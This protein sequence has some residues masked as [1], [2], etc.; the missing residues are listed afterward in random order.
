M[1]SIGAI[2]PNKSTAITA[3]VL[4]PI[5]AATASA[6][7]LKVRGSMSTNTGRAPTLCTAPAVAKNVNGVVTTSSPVPISSARSAR[8]IAS[9]PFAHPTAYFVAESPAT[10]HSSAATGSPR[11]NDWLSTTCIIASTTLSRI[12]ACCAFR[13]SRGTAMGRLV[14]G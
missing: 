13:S 5:A 3:F 8:R 1:A 4:G 14:S 6:L 10:A 2:C 11:M 7:M 12:V 9:V